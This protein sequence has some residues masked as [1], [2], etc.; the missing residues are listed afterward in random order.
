MCV[1]DKKCE[2]WISLESC[3]ISVEGCLRNHAWVN[4]MN[5]INNVVPCNQSVFAPMIYVDLPHIKITCI[6]NV[7]H[8][9]FGYIDLA[10]METHE[11]VKEIYVKRPIIHGTSLISEACI[12]KIVGES[13]ENAHFS[14]GAPKVLRIFKL[15]DGSVCFAMEQII[16]ACTLD[17]Y[18]DKLPTN[19]LPA[20][21]ID[22]IIQLCVMKWHL[23]NEIGM[24]HRDLKPSNCLIVEYAEP[25]TKFITIDKEILELSSKRSLTLIDFGF[26][27]IGNNVSHVADVSLS[28]VYP[29]SDPC[30]KVGRDMFLFLGLLYIDYHIYF[31]SRLIQLFE[32]WL[33][34]PG[35][36][37]CKFMRTDKENS[38]KWLY[39][40]TGNED[41]VR[42]NSCPKRIISDLRTF[43]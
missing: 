24:N 31:P 11:G 29:K 13:L 41:I 17:V 10:K 23:H 7:A 39:F 42:F 40:I 8:G 32:S 30:P 12:Q 28:T 37:F 18:L 9:N 4:E 34:E 3:G 36:N 5:R 38:K 19:Q 2:T 25:E 14:K 15:R 22:C 1:K 35:S 26:A 43:L 27:C 6:R 16:G 33:Q 21:I 20:A